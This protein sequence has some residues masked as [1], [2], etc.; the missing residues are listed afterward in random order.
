MN[1]SALFGKIL[2]ICLTCLCFSASSWGQI[3]FLQ[4]K[5]LNISKTKLSGFSYDDRVK[6]LLLNLL[7][8]GM[9]ETASEE[10]ARALQLNIFNTNHFSVVGP[11]EWNAQ[12]KDQD[13]T[14]ADCHDIACGVMI[15]NLFH[16]DKVLVGTIH[17][18]LMLN[19]NGKEEQSFIL[20]IRMVDAR[21]NITNFSDEVQFTVLQMNDE[22]FRLAARISDNTM[23]LGN[24]TSIKHSGITLY[25]GRAHGI[26]TGHRLV[27]SQR[28]SHKSV[29][30][31]KTQENIFQNVAL[32]EVVQ[33]SDLSSEA[34]I[35]QKIS[36]VLQGDQIKT[37]IDTEKLIHL[38]T[39]VRKE[40]DTQKRLKPK[41]QVI[42]LGPTVT[43]ESS[44]FSNWSNSF[45]RTKSLHD[46]WLYTTVGAGSITLLFLSG[47]I[48]INGLL[49]VLPWIV[50]AGTVYSGTR[51]LHY[52]DLLSEISTEGHIHGFLS[53]SLSSGPQG[54]QWTPIPKGIQ[55]VWGKR[56]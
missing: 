33:V 42:R 12:I 43:K 24:V 7:P 55:I 19:E 28:R 9:T 11:A 40:L 1:L 5:T 21:T 16:A 39:Q 49:S 44:D 37:Y 20:S 41:K 46:R 48:K 26:K 32:A 23:L 50:G 51:Y 4:E 31:E 15:G 22:L 13:P 56:F 52:R 30:A 27:I 36:T 18:E 34:V 38:I 47:S 8:S 25:L 6:V 3:E 53:S 10:I 45:K 14:L 29:L 17:S 54:W 2:L 35:I